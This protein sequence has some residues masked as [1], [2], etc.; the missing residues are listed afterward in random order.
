MDIIEINEKI[1]KLETLLGGKVSSDVDTF[2]STKSKIEPLKT[3]YG[4]GQLGTIKK[5]RYFETKRECKKY[6]Y[7]ENIDPYYITVE[8]FGSQEGFVDVMKI[9]VNGWKSSSSHIYSPD[10]DETIYSSRIIQD[11]TGKHLFLRRNVNLTK[12]YDKLTELGIKIESTN[13][14]DSVKKHILKQ[15]KE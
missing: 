9:T 4:C 6:R 14:D 15:T 3:I 12:I 13:E 1:V 7:T 5:E 8:Y 2:I 10:F 11:S